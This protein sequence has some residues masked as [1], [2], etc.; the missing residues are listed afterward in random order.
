M[1][2]KR[3]RKTLKLK[4]NFIVLYFKIQLMYLDKKIFKVG[5]FPPYL[6]VLITVSVSISRKTTQSSPVVN[7]KPPRDHTSANKKL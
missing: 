5:S 1:S 4:K 3:T 6:P 2:L 7:I